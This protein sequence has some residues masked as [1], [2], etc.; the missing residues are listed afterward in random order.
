MVQSIKKYISLSLVLVVTI[1]IAVACANMATPTGGPVDLDPP[2]VVRSSPGFNATRV[3]KGKITIDFDENVTI[4]NPSENVIITPPQ[5]A[6]P[7]IHS[8]NRRVTVELRDTLMPNTTYTVDFTDAIV[9]NNEENPLE[10]FSYS[11]STGDVV[12]SLAISGKVITADI[13]SR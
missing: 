5:K 8:V 12:D 1:L 2:K 3:A 4:K 9:D 6:F 13:L 11:F 10:N 7:I